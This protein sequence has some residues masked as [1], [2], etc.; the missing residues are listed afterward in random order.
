[1]VPRTLIRTGRS[2]PARFRLHVEMANTRSIVAEASAGLAAPELKGEALAVFGGKRMTEAISARQE[3]AL[4]WGKENNRLQRTTLG[5]IRSVN[6]RC[7]G[8]PS[9]YESR[10]CAH[11]PVTLS[12]SHW[13]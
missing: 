7:G 11:A 8:E 1:M 4:S 9:P 5:S 3:A 12:Q 2:P 10:C 6:L 13:R